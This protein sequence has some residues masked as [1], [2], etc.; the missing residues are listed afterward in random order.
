MQTST[1]TKQRKTNTPT[2]MNKT[3]DYSK[4]V[5]KREINGVIV[6]ENEEGKMKEFCLGHVFCS[7]N[8]D[9]SEEEQYREC[10]DRATKVLYRDGYRYMFVSDRGIPTPSLAHYSI[11][12]CMFKDRET[13]EKYIYMD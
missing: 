3:I 11:V 6:Y 1:I 13:A 7:Q 2:M 10:F 9:L 12:V 5:N 8:P 4:P